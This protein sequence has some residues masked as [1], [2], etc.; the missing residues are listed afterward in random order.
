MQY[1][2][3]LKALSS[4]EFFAGWYI[5]SFLFFLMKAVVSVKKSEQ[6]TQPKF[7]ILV[8]LSTSLLKNNRN[9]WI[10]IQNGMDVMRALRGCQPS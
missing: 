7:I 10:N 4:V 1:L 5:F 3:E 2:I 9:S 6:L 8:G